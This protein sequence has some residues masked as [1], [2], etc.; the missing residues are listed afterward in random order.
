M[1]KRYIPEITLAEF[2]KPV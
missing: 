1:C 2:R